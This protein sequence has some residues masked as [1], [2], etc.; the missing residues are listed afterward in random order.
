ML[1]EGFHL[2]FKADFHGPKITKNVF[3]GGGFCKI[4]INSVS[5]ID[6]SQHFKT[7]K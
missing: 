6:L 1:L 3:G 7:W 5:K 4:I 2:F